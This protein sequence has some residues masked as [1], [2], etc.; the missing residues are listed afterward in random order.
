MSLAQAFE[1]LD[2]RRA[3][4][5]NSLTVR[6][7]LVH[8]V[9]DMVREKAGDHAARSFPRPLQGKQAFAAVGALEFLDL[10][11]WALQRLAPHGVDA[12]RFY[13]EIGRR[14]VSSI[15]DTTIGR[16]FVSLA[17][18]DPVR[19]FESLG[20]GPSILV[21]FGE[22]R[23][24]ESAPGR[25]R[26]AFTGSVLPPRIFGGMYCAMAEGVGARAAHCTSTE[27]APGD[28]EHL[29]LWG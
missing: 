21:A 16:T 14:A 5:S 10:L 1:D 9:F 29:I 3:L 7:V 25:V 8:Q 23:V 19:L 24:V 13:E 15:R 20:S 27:P 2:G 6:A 22:R 18:G 4:A 17:A 12:E 11:G 28:S 26:I